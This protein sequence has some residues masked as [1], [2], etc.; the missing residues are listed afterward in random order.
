MGG[1]QMYSFDRAFRELF[2]EAQTE[3]LIAVYIFTSSASDVL[4]LI[5]DA[6]KRG[7]QVCLIVNDL[8]NTDHNRGLRQHLPELLQLGLKLWTFEPVHGMDAQA[9]YLHGKLLVADR[10]KALIG[11]FN[12]TGKAINNNHEV[13]VVVDGKAADQA[14]K[15]F[16]S[17]L[18]YPLVKRV[19]SV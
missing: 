8:L 1:G 19:Y 10:K 13:G 17:L 15:A 16:Q 12:L 2:A 6:L 11:S 3:I 14:G 5:T 7:L 18:K 4:S 9:T